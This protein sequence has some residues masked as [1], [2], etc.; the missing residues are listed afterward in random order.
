MVMAR[1]KPLLSKRQMTALLEFSKRH[2][3]NSQTMR[4]KILWFD[5]F[6]IELFG[7]N[8]KRHVWRKPGIIPMVKHGGAWCYGEA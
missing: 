6:K 5:E 7:L 4:N 1:W 2:L 8:A 3:K